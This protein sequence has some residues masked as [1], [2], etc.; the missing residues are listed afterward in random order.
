MR[1]PILLGATALLA[2]AVDIDID[3]AALRPQASA[4]H[5]AM[6]AALRAE[7]DQ[8][9]AAITAVA[10]SDPRTTARRLHIA[11]GDD[12]QAAIV[13]QGVPAEAMRQRIASRRPQANPVALA[14]D[15]LGVGLAGTP[16]PTAVPAAGSAPIS[17]HATPSAAPVLPIMRHITS[18]DATADGHGAVK[19]TVTAPSAA[20]AA[21]VE[22][23]LTA[24]RDHPPRLLP[25]AAR[26]VLAGLAVQRYDSVVHVA[27]DI[28]AATRDAWLAQAMRRLAER[29][30]RAD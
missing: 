19:A 14:S 4:L 8:S 23:R 5:D 26:T 21:A 11:I 24:L 16:A 22:A 1:I 10:G 9:C 12:H 2:A 7:F 6:P 17:V 18:I 30:P 3:L 20:D 29:L 28:P 27:A 25:E 15:V 13:L